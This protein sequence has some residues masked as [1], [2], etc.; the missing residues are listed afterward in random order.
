MM[1]KL[2]EAAGEAKVVLVLPLPRYVLHGCCES[3]AHV[4]NLGAADYQSLLASAT[5]T[6]RNVMEDALEGISTDYIFYNPVSTFTDGPLPE[7]KAIDGQLVWESDDLV[8]LM[9]AAYGD[10][11]LALL[12]LWLHSE[13]T[14]RKRVDSI[15]VDHAPH[16]YRGRG[17]HG[18]YRGG[19]TTRGRGW[20][21]QQPDAGPYSGCRF[22][23]YSR[24]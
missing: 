19:S 15:I 7:M 20:P 24:Q 2:V 12:D 10:V 14:T 22:N 1:K 5:H 17:G 13:F 21:H 9:D 16:N 8:H 6:C 3:P 11:G 4:T 18:G 23:P